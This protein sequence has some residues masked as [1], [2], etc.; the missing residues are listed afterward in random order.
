MN[1]F[2]TEASQLSRRAFVRNGSLFLLGAGLGSSHVAGLFAAEADA[3]R[4]VRIGLITDMHYADKAPAG[5]RHYRE[6]LGKLGEAAAQFAKDK[7]EFVVE[8]GD[9][10]DAADSVEVEKGYLKRIN[11]DFAALPGEKYS[12]TS[13]VVHAATS[14]VAAVPKLKNLPITPVCMTTV[15]VA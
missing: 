11:K 13:S 12:G 5:S 6:T 7:P 3:K 14:H 2:N 4:R 10:I 9:L 8:L 1:H 15:V